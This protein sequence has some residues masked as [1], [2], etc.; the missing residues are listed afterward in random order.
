[1]SRIITDE[2]HTLLVDINETIRNIM[3]SVEAMT[4]EKIDACFRTQLC[5]V[6][7]HELCHDGNRNHIESA[8]CGRTINKGL[9]EVLTFLKVA[10]GLEESISDANLKLAELKMKRICKYAF[11][12]A[13]DI[14]VKRDPTEIQRIEKYLRSTVYENLCRIKDTTDLIYSKCRN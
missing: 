5:I 3:C 4:D 8:V 12:V 7:L 2:A 10:V 14:T 1:M 6:K 9:T 13:C 11:T